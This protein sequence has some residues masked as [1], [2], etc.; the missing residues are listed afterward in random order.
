MLRLFQVG[1]I[2]EVKADETFPCDLIFLASSSVDG[3]C[4]VTTASLDG[5]SNFKVM[6]MDGVVL[7]GTWVPGAATPA[8]AWRGMCAKLEDAP[9]E[10]VPVAAFN[11]SSLCLLPMCRHRRALGIV[12]FPTAISAAAAPHGI[13]IYRYSFAALSPIVGSAIPA[14]HKVSGVGKAGPAAALAP[15]PGPANVSVT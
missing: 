5:E 15:S 8:S 4:Y 7:W 9:A 2:V 11:S 1:D 10:P 12:G 3:T 13:D 14:P 6:G